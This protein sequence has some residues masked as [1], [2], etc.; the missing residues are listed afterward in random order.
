MSKFWTVFEIFPHRHF[1]SICMVAVFLKKYDLKSCL[2]DVQNVGYKYFIR[3]DVW[4]KYSLISD[5]GTKENSYLCSKY[6]GFRK[7]TYTPNLL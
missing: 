1:I 6:F 2:L 4:L 7:L 3:C 5:H